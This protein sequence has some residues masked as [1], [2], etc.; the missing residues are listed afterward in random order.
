M[1]GPIDRAIARRIT[2]ILH[3]CQLE[4]RYADINRFRRVKRLTLTVTTGGFLAEWVDKPEHGGGRRGDGLCVGVS[5]RVWGMGGGGTGG[6][7]NCVVEASVLGGD[8]AY[9]WKDI[10]CSD[11]GCT[12]EGSWSMGFVTIV[13]KAK[14]LATSGRS[15]WGGR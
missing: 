12:V 15:N 6:D 8:E 7:R 11:R 1:V 4:E 14:S 13:D 9:F 3:A 2:R 5:G 10:V